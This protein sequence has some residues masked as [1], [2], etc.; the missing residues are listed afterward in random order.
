L[1][2]TVEQFID[3]KS[4]DNLSDSIG[5][6]LV[7]GQPIDIISPY[8]WMQPIPCKVVLCANYIVITCLY[9]KKENLK[10]TSSVISMK[11]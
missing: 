1:S 4:Q 8:A 6:F 7:D 5:E 2:S 3:Y 10:L 11:G 9:N